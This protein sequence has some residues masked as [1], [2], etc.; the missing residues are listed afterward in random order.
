VFIP[1]RLTRI[2]PAERAAHRAS[3]RRL[4]P[5]SP[6]KTV[7]R[8]AGTRPFGSGVVVHTYHPA[9]AGG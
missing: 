5:E 4:F 7:L 6:H 9:T 8:L 2:A 1:G 3:G